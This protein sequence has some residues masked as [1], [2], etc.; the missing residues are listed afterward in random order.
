MAEGLRRSAEKHDAKP[1]EQQV[2]VCRKLSL[3]SIAVA[4]GEVRT[5]RLRAACT[6]HL[7]HRLR[8]VET[9]DRASGADHARKFDRGPAASATDVDH[10][11]SRL[12][13]RSLQRGGTDRHDDVVDLLL[14]RDPSLTQR[15]VP[16]CNL[17][18]VVSLHGASLKSRD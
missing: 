1:R 7:E 15:T 3:R 8:Y 12:R 14:H 6:R 17:F 5:I 16:F 2:D 4:E 9:K 18:R 13:R 10:P 11:L